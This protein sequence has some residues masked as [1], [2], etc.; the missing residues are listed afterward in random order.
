MHLDSILTFLSYFSS[1]LILFL[2]GKYVYKVNNRDIDINNELLVKDNFAFSLSYVGYLFG[3]ILGII[4]AIVGDSK[5]IVEDLI[6]IFLYGILS[7]ALLNI[8][9]WINDNVILK[10]F[11]IKKEII[12]DQNPGMGIIE[13]AVY[14]STGL[15]IYAAIL[16]DSGSFFTAIVYWLIGMLFLILAEKVYN[17]ITPF[18]IH[19]EIEKDNVAVGI[20]FAGAIIAIANVIRYAASQEFHSWEESIAEL[21]IDIIIALIALPI[22]RFITD[23]LLLPG[24]KLSDELVNQEKPN[25]AAGLIEAFAYIGGSILITIC[26]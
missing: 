11:K 15:I 4:S 17:L 24:Y 3:L 26:L 12:E 14:I 21:V 2:L 5:G 1:C 6:D 19:K 22:I 8:S 20:A 23:K 18:N 10:N 9:H 7:I 13:F 25:L 16:G